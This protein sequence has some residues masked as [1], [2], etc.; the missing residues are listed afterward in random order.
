[1]KKSLSIIFAA[2]LMLGI[3]TDA[4]FYW[5]SSAYDNENAYTMYSNKNNID[6]HVGEGRCSGFAVRL[7]TDI[8]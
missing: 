5:T 2:L 1:M 6:S 8:Q 7:V 4:S 3:G